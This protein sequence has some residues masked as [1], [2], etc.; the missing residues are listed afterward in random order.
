MEL[1]IPKTKQK[2]F[3][4]AQNI[5]AIIVFLLCF[6]IYV[7]F[8]LSGDN[9]LL[10]PT[11]LKETVQE[12]GAFGPLI[13]MGILA[14]SV[15]VSPIPGAPLVIAGG[16]IWEFPLAGIYSI[17]GG[18]SGG[19]FAYLIGRYFAAST[20]EAITGKSINLGKK[21]QEQSA[22]WFV[23]LSRLLPVL[24]FG[25]ISYA[26]GVAR[27]PASS[28]LVGTLLGMIP[29]TLLL[30]Y[31]GKSLTLSVVQE[32]MMLILAVILV[33]TCLFFLLKFF[34]TVKLSI[35]G[36]KASLPLQSEK[37]DYHFRSGIN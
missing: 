27:L 32:N 35:R 36:N 21:Y 17:V 19:V 37:N 8:A 13:Y 7:W 28:Y 20:I 29:P 4:N 9:H 18:F 31:F 11:G 14:L 1:T 5:I 22:G 6:T 26:S 25:F 23:F 16:V 10:T 30:S 33:V 3:R 2:Q 24:P 15:V 34:R 12:L